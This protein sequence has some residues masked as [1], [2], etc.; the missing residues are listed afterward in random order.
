MLWVVDGNGRGRVVTSDAWARGEKQHGGRVAGAIVYNGE[1][2]NDDELREELQQRGVVFTSGSDTETVVAAI[3]VWGERA[4]DRLRGMYA[5]AWVDVEKGRLLL[6]RDPLGIK[7]LYFACVQS[8]GRDV[9]YV[10]SEVKAVLAGE[11]VDARPDPVVVS[12]Y[13]TTIRTT[14]GERTLYRGISTLEPGQRVVF[15]ADGARMKRSG[16]SW[17]EGAGGDGAE[18]VMDVEG[19][20]GMVVDSVKRHLRSDVP[21]CCLLS[22]GLDSS[23]VARCARDLPVGFREREM[24]T[25]CAG[26]DAGSGGSDDFAF[27]S[28]MA[29]EVGSRHV[30]AR[31]TR[32]MFKERWSS[33]VSRL[34]VPL[35]TPNEVAINEVARTLRGMGYTVALSGEGADELFGG[36]DVIM[37]LCAK[38]VRESGAAWREQGGRFHLDLAA[39][40]PVDAKDTVLKGDVHAAGERDLV[41]V[42]EYERI[43]RECAAGVG[44]ADGLQAHLRFQRRVNLAGLLLRLDQATMLESVEGRTPLADQVVAC[45][46]E[47]LAMGM[48][49]VEGEGGVGGVQH[50]TKIALREGFGS[51]LPREIAVRPKASFPLPFQGWVGDMAGVLRESRFAKEW[52]TEEAIETVCRYPEQAWKFAWPMVNLAV[53]RG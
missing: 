10:G 1:L 5:V 16:W 51:V 22:G 44:D 30:E 50:R 8:D 19:V 23:I 46:A 2:Y 41:L 34:A 3:G 25:F 37:G 12:S 47:R 31:V 6:A 33:M 4:V 36:Y 18:Q 32:E 14:L 24:T 35:S 40:V 21:V 9:V 43:F 42:G 17:W 28:V 29:K 27:A 13:L 38:M 39:W 26:A 45:A 20:R 48:K 11:G 7:P 52:F 53:W 49:F 15:S